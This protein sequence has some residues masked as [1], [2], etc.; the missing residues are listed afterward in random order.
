MFKFS[1]RTT[2]NNKK[3]IKFKK[4]DSY[5]FQQNKKYKVQILMY[6]IVNTI[7]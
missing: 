7:K 4:L 2:P 6:I 1:L 5:H 3:K